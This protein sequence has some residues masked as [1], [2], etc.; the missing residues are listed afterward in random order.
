MAVASKMHASPAFAWC[1][2]NER[3]YHSSD[4]TYN[5]V[6]ACIP[7]LNLEHLYL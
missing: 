1:C 3:L 5:H 7:E 6:I 4:A 2:E